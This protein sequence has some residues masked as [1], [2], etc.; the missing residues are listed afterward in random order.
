[1]KIYGKTIWISRESEPD[2][3][4]DFYSDFDVSGEGHVS[5]DVA[6]NGHYALYLNGEL[7]KVAASADYPHYR[8]FDRVDI[9]ER[10]AARNR[11]D[12][13]VWYPGVDSQTYIK[14]DAGL[15]FS[16]SEGNRVICRSSHSTPSRKNTAYRNGY[17]KTITSQLGLSFYY[18]AGVAS[19]DYSDSWESDGEF[20]F[21]LRKYAAYPV[22]GRVR[23]RVEKIDGGY[24]VD[25]GEE[26]VGFLDL[27]LKSEARKYLKIAYAEHL[28]D[29]EVVADIG[30]RDFSL[31]YVARK[32]EN[33]YMNPFRRIACRYLRV[34]CDGEL[35][36]KYIGLRRAERRVRCIPCRF[37]DDLLDRIYSTSV[38]TLKKCMHEH[39]ED[40]PWRE[41]AMYALDSRNQMLCGYYA[42]RGHGYQR[43]NL[44]FM[45]RGQREDGLLPLCFPAGIDIP[46][47]FFSLAY[48]MQ[49]RD[50]AEH[51]GDESV[52]RM[53]RPTL[54]R[55]ISAF[56]G[57]IDGSGLIP[58]F[59]YPYWNFYEWADESNNEWEIGRS[60][61]DPY[62]KKYDLILNCMYVYARRIYDEL[63]G[64]HSD[65]ET[66][67]ERIRAAFY[68]GESGLYRLSTDT[69]RSSQLGN[70]LAVLI[71]IGDETL[72]ER[73]ARGGDGII[74]VTL[75]MNTFYYDALLLFGDKYKDFIIND[76]R[77]KYGRMLDEGATA[78]WETENGWRD[79]DGA[80]SLCHGW[81]A[82][83]VYYLTKL[84]ENS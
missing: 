39:Y 13:S 15:F 17:L 5:I 63:Y 42:F 77:R 50:Y 12:I 29:G 84:C 4:A 6:C 35:D 76:I 47:P 66:M 73:T 14:D 43:E 44:L 67:A 59:E 38:N 33:R 70:S 75:S 55:I 65:T 27:E 19:G 10:C 8:T 45:A 28:T 79:F 9:T 22:G 37:G 3:Y 71:G 56:E 74:G 60:A 16:V 21:N 80:G 61:R 58:D 51:T 72:M 49:V 32:G 62:V 64:E 18:D 20:E 24:L 23:S 82:I 68:D 1:M 2:T 7:I 36:I 69:R 25:L 34:E 40:C 54:D 41:Q 31:E 81:S 30:G 57:R 46:I 78:F 52:P 11:L 83:P 26:Q 48:F 53:L